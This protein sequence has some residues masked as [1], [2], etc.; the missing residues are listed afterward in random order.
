MKPTPETSSD[1]EATRNV[2]S[3]HDEDDDDQPMYVIKRD[4]SKQE[5]HFDKI[6]ERISKLCD[7]K[8]P[9]DRRYVDPVKIAQKVIIGIYPGVKTTELDTLAAETAAYQSV[10]HFDLDS[11]AA[12]IVISSLQKETLGDIVKVAE[13]LHAYVNPKTGKRGKLISD[14]A[15]AF[16]QRNGDALKETMDYE[17]DFQQSYF[18]FMTL[19]KSYLIKCNGKPVER[20]QDLFM[21]TS[22]G[23]HM[24]DNAG[25][26]SDEENLR[27]LVAC[28]ETYEY[29]SKGFFIHATPTLFNSG[30]CTPQMSSCFLVDMK[31]DSIDGIYDTLK[32]CA[33]ISKS[34]GGIGVSISKIRA[35]QSYISGTGGDSNGIVP[36]LRV[37]NDTARYVDQG[38]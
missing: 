21:R 35:S 38:E 1:R 7:M 28:I 36:M 4:G 11:L 20:L 8:P 34:A 5:I 32:Q 2:G 3:T 22:V 29:L 18:G 31:E 15:L 23:M 19:K 6:T 10:R 14:D 27:A 26:A 9:L 17:R 13:K 12:R 16:I 37:F 25:A 33:M 30:T 24:P